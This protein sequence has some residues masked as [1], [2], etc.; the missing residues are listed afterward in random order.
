M[1]QTT[2]PGAAPGRPR[3][4]RPTGGC[5]DRPR[6]P[7]PTRVETLPPLSGAFDDALDPGLRDLGLELAPDARRI[8]SDHVRL[9]LAW[10]AAINLTSIRDPAAIAIRH[11]V[12]SLAAVPLLLSRRAAGANVSAFLDLGSGGGFPGVPL[13]AVVP[14]ER[15]ALVESVGK[16]AAYLATVVEATDLAPRVSVAVARAEDLAR[17]PGHRE[18]WPVVTVRAVGGLDEL[19][20]LAFPLL[21]PGGMLVAWK[22]GDI[23]DETAAALRAVAG[24]GGGRL[25]AAPVR[26]RGLEGH[27][28]VVVTKRGRTADAYPR[29]PAARR[30][31]PW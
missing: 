6:E 8:I 15:V 2:T 7:L 13:A 26:V 30:H 11:V 17:D 5:L 28:L 22:G 20:E 21:V 29:D 12:D 9:L 1:R 16:K 23:V 10:N 4:A 24:M 31:R 3:E 19:V 25:E 27:R 14:V 18:R